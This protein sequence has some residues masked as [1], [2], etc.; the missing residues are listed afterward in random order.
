MEVTNNQTTINL[1]MDNV[2]T[3]IS[4]H[5]MMFCK[6]LENFNFMKKGK[7]VISVR[8]QNFLDLE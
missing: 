1:E 4:Y 2:G 6:T 8:I 3:S 5:D 7:M